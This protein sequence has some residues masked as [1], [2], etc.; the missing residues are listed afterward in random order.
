MKSLGDNEDF[1][2]KKDPEVVA[3]LNKLVFSREESES[4][5]FE[6]ARDGPDTDLVF[7]APLW[8]VPW[9]PDTESYHVHMP[10]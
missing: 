1:F 3:R 9:A 10:I 7:N 2:S 5:G 6:G 8:R 4:Y